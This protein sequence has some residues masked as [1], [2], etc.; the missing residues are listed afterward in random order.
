VKK[1]EKDVVCRH[2]DHAGYIYMFMQWGIV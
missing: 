2:D 1:R